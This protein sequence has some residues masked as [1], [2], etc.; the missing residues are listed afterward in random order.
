MLTIEK[1]LISLMLINNG[2]DILLITGVHILKKFVDGK[3]TDQL[4]GMR[5][6]CVLPANKYEQITIKLDNPVPVITP[7]ELEA[8]GGTVKAK[9]KGFEG[10]FYKDN[11]SGDYRFTAKAT[12]LEVIA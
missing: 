1:L 10:R 7:E 5:Y 3:P 12:S 8:K 11:K 6:T 9:A 4:D 2:S